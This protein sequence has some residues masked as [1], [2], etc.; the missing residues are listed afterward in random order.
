MQKSYAYSPAEQREGIKRSKDGDGNSVILVRFN[1][2]GNKELL[3]WNWAKAH[4]HRLVKEPQA[5]YHT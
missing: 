1:S 5:A 2:A 3:P 4:P